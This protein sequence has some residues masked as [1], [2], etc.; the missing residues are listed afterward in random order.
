MALALNRLVEPKRHN[1]SVRASRSFHGRLETTRVR[2]GNR[3]AAYFPYT[4][5][6][7]AML[8]AQCATQHTPGCQTS[9]P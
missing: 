1:D 3:F 8:P 9:L 7:F 2:A 4:H 6:T 5:L